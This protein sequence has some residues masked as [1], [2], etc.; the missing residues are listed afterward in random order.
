MIINQKEN[1]PPPPKPCNYTSPVLVA[2]PVNG[3]EHLSD[4]FAYMQG[5]KV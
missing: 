1:A 4:L 3:L 5:Q 2:S